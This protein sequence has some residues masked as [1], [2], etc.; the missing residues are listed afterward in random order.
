MNLKIS[1]YLK[2]ERIE[3]RPVIFKINFGYKE[4][5]LLT[6][7]SKYKPLLYNSQ[8]KVHKD[9]WNKELGLPTNNK[10][11]AE[12]LKMQE[13]IENT[14]EHLVLQKIEITPNS[15]R[16]ELDL[17]FGR[18]LKENKGYIGIV[19]YIENV[20]LKENDS[21]EKKNRKEATLKH[22]RKLK[23]KIESFEELSGRKMT[24][25]NLQE[26]SYL[27]FINFIRGQVNRINSVWDIQK[28]LNTVL[29]EIARKYK[30]HV[31][32]PTESLSKNDIVSASDEEKIYMNYEQINV[33]LDY[34]PENERLRNTKL[35]LITLLFTGCRYSDVFKI[36]PDYE[37]E[38]K[39]L[40]FRYA[41]FVDE[42][43]NKD[44]VVPFLKPLEDAI[45]QNEGNLPY[46]I[47]D[48]KFN[49]YVKE[50]VDLAELNDEIALAYTN[51]FGKTE[52]E[53]KKYSDFVTSHIGRRSFITNL[54]NYVPVTI[55]SKITGHSL[56]NKSVFFKYNKVSVVDNAALFMKELKRVAKSNPKDFPIPLV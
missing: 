32:N 55:L 15:L 19:D 56:T 48:V 46:K 31:F 9:Y 27:D 18:K 41:R 30:I 44:V 17:I 38:N 51:S 11:I 43:T 28:L 6:N 24:V 10:L 36:R 39:G 47:S 14:F 4:T 7:E 33:V 23:V 12:L 25:Q 21:K 49:K 5:N 1:K 22:F 42:K 13:V 29:K 34:E 37:Y 3:T 8:I 26:D 52:Y 16:E 20:L 35:I 45:K 2:N 40:K 54:I 53:V 50:L